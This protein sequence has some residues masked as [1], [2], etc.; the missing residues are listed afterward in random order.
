[1][2]GLEKASELWR[3]NFAKIER[4]DPAPEQTNTP[5]TMQDR[6]SVLDDP[7]NDPG[8]GPKSSLLMNDIGYLRQQLTSLGA[9]ILDVRI[10]VCSARSCDL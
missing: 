1:M 10:M 6:S 4:R 3:D 5:S 8:F 2:S 9:Q 7:L